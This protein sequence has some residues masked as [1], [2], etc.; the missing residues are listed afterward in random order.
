MTTTDIGSFVRRRATQ[1]DAVNAM[2]DR[3]RELRN[4]ADA[5]LQL[6]AD[7]KARAKA[8]DRREQDLISDEESLQK[9]KRRLAA[10]EQSLTQKEDALTSEAV[11][12]RFGHTMAV[13]DELEYPAIKDN[14]AVVDNPKA[15]SAAIIR[16]GAK[17]RGEITDVPLPTDKT[18]RAIVLAGMRRRGE[19]V[20]EPKPRTEHERVAALI[21]QAGRRRRGEIP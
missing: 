1:S 16:A 6:E 10:S 20:E 9:D 2:A 13:L 4:R 17:R 8:L 21:I 7:L 19:L 15:L 5:L 18:A 14:E 3:A 12:E 11:R